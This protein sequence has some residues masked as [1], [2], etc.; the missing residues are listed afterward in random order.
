V[1]CKP[2]TLK[3]ATLATVPQATL[4]SDLADFTLNTSNFTNNNTAYAQGFSLVTL[5]DFSGAGS[6]LEIQYTG[7]PEPGTAMLILGGAIP[8]LMNRRR[9]RR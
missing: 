4:N 3:I 1:F 9:R 2:F 8:M 6:D 5:S 7:T